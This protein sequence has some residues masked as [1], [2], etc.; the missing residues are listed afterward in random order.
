MK[1]AKGQ[2][3]N[4]FSDKLKKQL[5]SIRNNEIDNCP[6]AEVLYRYFNKE[7]PGKEKKIFEDHLDLCPLCFSTL[8]SLKTAGKK[9]MEKTSLNKNWSDIEKELDEKFYSSLDSISISEVETTKAPY[10]KKYF[11]IL[12]G[13]LFNFSDIFLTPRIIAYAGSVAVLLIISLYSIAYFNRSDFYYLSEIK[14]EQQAVLRSGESKFLTNGLELFADGKYKQAI[15]DF[16]S[17]VQKN[18]ANYPANY[19]LGLC[20]L[21]ISKTGLPG[22]P[23]KYDTSMVKN[24][25]KYLEVALT[26]AGENQFYQEDCYWYLGKAYLMIGEVD[27]AKMQFNKILNLDKINLM[28][29]E[30]AREM[31][32]LLE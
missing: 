20:Y 31:V 24:G 2:V 25:I 9:K 29:K 17:F 22:M 8:D 10:W 7:L 32:S 30:D 15:A 16:D 3:K 11:E 5:K 1:K 28:R 18:Q 6:Q 27:K 14:P 13:K 23:Y 19:Y 12:R 21:N 4:D 26:N